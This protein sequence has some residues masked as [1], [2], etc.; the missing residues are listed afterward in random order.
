MKTKDIYMKP[1]IEV[2]S[3]EVMEIIAASV[4]VGKGD[5]IGPAGSKKRG[6]WG[7]DE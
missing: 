4:Q 7:E 2:E 5:H 3:L 1:L 6:F